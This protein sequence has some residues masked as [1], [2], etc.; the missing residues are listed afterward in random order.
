MEESF[1]SKERQNKILPLVEVVKEARHQNLLSL[2]LSL[3]ASVPKMTL[4]ALEVIAE[5]YT[6]P[7]IIDKVGVFKNHKERREW[8]D[9]LSQ[10]DRKIYEQNLLR[11]NSISGIFTAL[12]IILVQLDKDEY[13][14]DKRRE[15]GVKKD[16][17][18]D[19]Y[20]QEIIVPERA[21]GPGLSVEERVKFIEEEVTPLVKEFIQVI[22]ERYVHK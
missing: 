18:L 16:R 7:F 21:G 10:E 14:L 4:S 6:Y 13:D 17:L 1:G 8:R 22:K 3:F 15:L 2:D 9:S 11:G 5:V 12:G 20:T 19:K